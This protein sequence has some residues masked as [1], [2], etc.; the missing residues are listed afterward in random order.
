MK[1]LQMLCPLCKRG[2]ALGRPFPGSGGWVQTCFGLNRPEHLGRRHHF[3]PDTG[4]SLV[5]QNGIHARILTML[6]AGEAR[7]LRG[8]PGSFLYDRCGIVVVTADA[9]DAAT[10]SVAPKIGVWARQQEQEGKLIALFP[11][12]RGIHIVGA[13]LRAFRPGAAS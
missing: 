6:A 13:Q 12:V 2:D 9:I 3:N 5:V 8:F 10:A 1:R 11:V 4:H 7:D